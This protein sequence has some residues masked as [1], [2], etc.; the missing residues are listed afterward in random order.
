VYPVDYRLPAEWEAHSALLLAWPTADGDWRDVLEPVRDEYAGLINAVVE[1]QRVIL[2]V[3]PKDESARRRL[4][5]LPGLEF[6]AMPYDDTWCRDYG[7][8]VMCKTGE[9]LAL[10]F[11]FNG[12]GGK[13]EARRDNLVNALLAQHRLFDSFEFRQSP[14]E[15]EGGAID[16][17]GNGTLLFNR[18]C[19]RV[20]HPQLQ[21]DEVD[22]QLSAWL[23]ASRLIEIDVPPLPGD[24]TD[25]HID[26]L[27]RFVAADRIAF[28]T[29]ADADA[30]RRLSGQLETLRCSDERAYELLALPAP[31]DIDATI[32]ASY[33]N[34]VLVNGAVL[35]PRYGSRSDA[36]ALALLDEA[37]PSRDALSV[38]ARTLLSQ[39][40]GPHCAC[41]HIPES[42]A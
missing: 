24:D 21:D 42:L 7:P 29:L 27:A 1:R 9:R 8:I 25:G 12:W 37:F 41:M 11:H 31:D 26:T 28:Q 22:Q 5:R 3:P 18:H 4:G 38:S 39:G 2:L 15:I 23:G 19:L 16:C 32:P 34:F 17:D 35:V 33:A 40:G 13:H 14:F 30:N 20:R 6:V 36:E 10:D